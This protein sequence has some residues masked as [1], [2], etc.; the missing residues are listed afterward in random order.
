MGAGNISGRM[1]GMQ[2]LQTKLRN[3]R[4]WQGLTIASI[5]KKMQVDPKYLVNFES[6]ERDY[7]SCNGIEGTIN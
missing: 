2:T 4:S 7:I 3:L 5:A 6:G 1:Q